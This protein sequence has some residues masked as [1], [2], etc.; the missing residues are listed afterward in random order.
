MSKSKS[1]I[2]WTVFIPK[3]LKEGS[4]GQHNEDISCVN[5]NKGNGDSLKTEKKRK[6]WVGVVFPIVWVGI[7]VEILGSNFIFQ[8]PFFVFNF[9]NV[10]T[11]WN[12]RP[13]LRS[14]T[15]TYICLK[16][17]NLKMC[18]FWRYTKLRKFY[19]NLDIQ[20]YF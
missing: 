13:T 10:Q 7:E 8:S 15:C 11:L 3:Y 12:M 4:S 2:Y 14:Q 18:F 5:S 16:Y 9:D 17:F 20:Y 19:I 1:I 6:M